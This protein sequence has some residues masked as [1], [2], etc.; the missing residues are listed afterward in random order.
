MASEEAFQIFEDNQSPF[1]KASI[2]DSERNPWIVVTSANIMSVRSRNLT[3]R[4]PF[5]TRAAI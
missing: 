2:Q 3:I 4:T 1:K 5:Y